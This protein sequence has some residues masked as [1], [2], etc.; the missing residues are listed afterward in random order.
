MEDYITQVKE[1]SGVS[2]AAVV[3]S[4]IIL[5]YLIISMV[6]LGP[7]SQIT[8]GEKKYRLPPVMGSK[9]MPWFNFYWFSKAP[10]DWVEGE[11]RKAAST[12]GSKDKVFTIPVMGERLTFMIGPSAHAVFMKSTDQQVSQNE[13]YAFMNPIFGKNVIYD[14]PVNVRE[15]QM[16]AAAT[17]LKSKSLN[18]YVEKIER[19]C[20][21]YF[22]EHWAGKQSGQANLKEDLS[23]LIILTASRCLMG[24]EIREK[25]FADVARLYHDLDAGITPLSIFFPNAPIPSHFTRDRA[26][27]EMT[28]IFTPLIQNRRL[29]PEE[30]APSDLLQVLCQQRYKDDSLMTEDEITGMLIAVL[31]AG[32]HTSSITTTWTIMHLLKDT[33]SLNRVMAEMNAVLG[34]GDVNASDKETLDKLTFLHSCIKEAIRM[35][36]PLIYLMRLVKEDL[37][38]KDQYIPKGDRIFASLGI[39]GRL[40]HVFKSPEKFDPDRWLAPRSEG[41]A[42]FAWIGFGGGLHTCLGYSF[43]STSISF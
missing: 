30:D 39:A 24:D 6:F 9:L 40:D 13:V 7:K 37:Y 17:G 12:D 10:I 31:F 20:R 2:L 33:S 23:R 35:H 18:S 4:T 38:F 3:L 14:A 29:I 26:R 5:S 28:K 27:R 43:F 42:P 32:Q 1:L 34:T 15:R 16:K 41:D 36:P 19:E 25:L 21:V 22:T 11:Y 8:V